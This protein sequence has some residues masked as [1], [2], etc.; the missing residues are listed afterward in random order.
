MKK[1]RIKARLRK[2]AQ[3]AQGPR[4]PQEEPLRSNVCCSDLPPNEQLK[5]DPDEVYGDTEIPHRH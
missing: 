5:K 4:H 3:P 2:K 1:R